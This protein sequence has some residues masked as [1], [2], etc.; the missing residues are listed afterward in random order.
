MS[1]LFVS[2]PPF[3]FQVW[4]DLEWNQDPA[5]LPGK[6]LRPLTAL[7]FLLLL[8]RLFLLALP[9]VLGTPLLSLWS[10]PSFLYPRSDLPRSRQGA[11]LTYLGSLSPHDLVLWTDDSVPFSFGKGGSNVLAGCSLFV[12]PRPL[13]PFPQ[14]QYAQASLINPAPLCKLFAGFGS[15]NKSTTSL[16]FSSYLTLVLSSPPYPLLHL[17]FHLIP[18]GR[19]GRNWL[20]QDLSLL[21]FDQATMGPGTLL[22]LGNNAARRGALVAPSAIPCSL[23]PLISHIHLSLFFQTGMLPRHARCVLSHLRCN[24]H[25]LLLSFYFFRIGRIENLSCSACGHS[26]QDTSHLIL[27]CPATDSLHRSHFGDSLFLSL[28]PPVQALGSFPA[29]GAP[30]SSAMPPSLGRSRITTT[31]TNV[32]RI[33]PRLYH[34]TLQCRSTSC[35]VLSIFQA[36][37]KTIC[38]W[39]Q[40]VRQGNSLFL[41]QLTLRHE[42]QNF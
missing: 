14:A 38:V 7:R 12:A 28:Q 30:W 16:L 41:L 42:E 5:D 6:P 34:S 24:E 31:T 13:F 26:S 25:S 32:K 18:S 22:S 17:F 29:S 1:G 11:A 40:S 9:F 10:S 39:Q 2:H 15:T 8:G 35:Y 4:P 20:F 23:F 33:L 19:S 27:H 37:I 3:P 21:L 36:K